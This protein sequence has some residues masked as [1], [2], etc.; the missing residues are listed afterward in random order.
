[1]D[2]RILGPLEVRD[3]DREVRLRGGQAACVAGAAARQRQPHAGDRPDRRRPLGRGRARERAEDGAD[4]RLEAPQG[5]DAR[6]CCTRARPATPSSWRRTTST[7][8]DSSSS[9]RTRG[10]TSTR[11]RA[12]EAAAGSARRW[13][14]GAGRRS[15]SS[16]RSRSRRRR[17]RGSRSFAIAAL[18][19]R[20]EADLL[21]GRHGELV[22]E[23]EAADRPLSAA[24]GPPAAAHAGAVPVGPAGGGADCVSGG[25]ART[26]R[27]ARHRALARAA[28][29]RATESSSRTRA[30]IR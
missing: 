6:R 27:R 5:A 9:S 16:R 2:F 20:L 12:E 11:A 24:R 23:L 4:P 30:S 19:G 8:T 10:Q 29:A 15:R 18:E 21:L 28:R 26:G 1:M 17:G 7:C 14:C 13:S 22:G 3:G 25:E